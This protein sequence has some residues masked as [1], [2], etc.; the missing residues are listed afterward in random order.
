MKRSVTERRVAALERLKN[1]AF[2]TSRAKRRGSLT[3][4]EWQ[5]RKDAN[6]SHL[7]DLI[8]GRKAN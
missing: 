2:E 7:E 5:D 1:S 6:I 3:N 8:H 4:E